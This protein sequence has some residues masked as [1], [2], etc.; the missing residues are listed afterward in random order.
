MSFWDPIFNTNDA[1]ASE[2]KTPTTTTP[3]SV[4]TPTTSKSSFWEG[5][6]GPLAAKEPTPTPETPTA[7]VL[8]SY[9]SKG[10]PSG[11][12]IGYS[13]DQA[14]TSGKPFFAY[15][16]PGDTATTTDRTRV[17]TTFDPTIATTTNSKNFYNPR[18]PKVTKLREVMGASYSD[19]LDHK[20]SLE[21]SGSNTQENLQ[22]EPLKPG[23]NKTATDALENSLARDVANGRKS[24]VEAQTELATAKKLKIPW[25]PPE[26][27]PKKEASFWDKTKA[28]LGSVFNKPETKPV[29]FPEFKFEDRNTQKPAIDFGQAS[30]KTA[31]STPGP[32]PV[33][34]ADIP[35]EQGQPETFW[36]RAQRQ[37]ATLTATKPSSGIE[38]FY[39]E[40]VPPVVKA[41]V[42]Q[43]SEGIKGRGQVVDMAGNLVEDKGFLEN[44]GLAKSDFAKVTDR[45]NELVN[46]G[47]D[48]TR[49]TQIAVTY[50]NNRVSDP[51][52]SMK[53]D[54]IQ[55]KTIAELNLTP[56]EKSAL[57]KVALF[58][59]VNTAL[60]ALN[61][62]GIGMVEKKTL[63][64]ISKI[65]AKETYTVP[66]KNILVK[67]VPNITP[68]MAQSA[69]EILSNVKDPAL[70]EKFISEL[71][72]SINKFTPKTMAAE[73][74]AIGTKETTVAKPAV[75]EG[76]KDLSTKTL[77]KL[78]GKTTVSKQFISDLTNSS[79]L[80]QEE[81]DVLL[82]ALADYKD[83]SSVPVKEFA[84]KV[85]AELLPLNV[86]SP[87][88]S[89]RYERVSLPEDQ[90]GPI[91]S[92]YE[93]IYNSPVKTSAGDIH[94]DGATAN[95][96]GHTRV[97]DLPE[98][99]GTRRVIEVQ[100]DLFQKGNIEKQVPP[101]NVFNSGLTV[102]YKGKPY[103]VMGTAG[104]RTFATL[105]SGDEVINNVYV[106][107]VDLTPSNE[108]IKKRAQEVSKLQ[109]YT[110]P[111]AHFRMVRE[112]IK[113]AAQDGKTKLQFP[114][115][116]TAMK[117]EG[118]GTGADIW[119]TADREMNLR[120]EM[121]KVGKEITQGQNSKW[122]ITDVLGNGKFKAVQKYF[123][124]PM[125]ARWLDIEKDQNWESRLTSHAET[126]D[127][128]GKVDTNNPIYKFYEKDLGRY[129]T[130]K[131]GA[132]V[133]TDKQGVKWY[134]ID[135]K[136]EQAKQP[137][138][139]F[140]RGTT[141]GKI[142]KQAES[143][144]VP[145]NMTI[146][147]AKKEIEKL[148]NPK[149]IDFLFPSEIKVE[150][151]EAW[152]RSTV[153]R[154]FKNPLIE[155]VQSNGKIND[156]TLYHES[157]HTYLKQFVSPEE[158][159]ALLTAI[160]KNKTSGLSR[161]LYKLD[162][163]NT[164]DER[165]EEYAA[166]A[167]ADYVRSKKAPKGTESIFAKI[168][169]RVREWIRKVTG[170]QKMFD[171][172]LSKKRT[173]AR[174]NYRTLDVTSFKNKK[175]LTPKIEGESVASK[176]DVARDI[177]NQ[178]EKDL[179]V[180]PVEYTVIKPTRE[181][182]LAIEKGYK[183]ITKIE[184]EAL[185]KEKLKIKFSPEM[186]QK[187]LGLAIREEELSN[188]RL[189]GLTKFASKTGDNAG[190]LPEVTGEIGK[191]MFKQRGDQYISEIAGIEDTEVARE[192]FEK[193]V[194]RKKMF[195]EDMKAFM[196]EKSAFLREERAKRKE[197]LDNQALGKM[198]TAQEKYIS[199]V[200]GDKASREARIKRIQ[201]METRKQEEFKQ[202]AFMSA[203]YSRKVEKANLESGQKKNLLAKFKQYLAPISQTDKTTQE[204]WLNWETKKLKAKEMGND[205]YEKFKAQPENDMEA[206]LE[207]EAG[208]PIAW[209]RNEFDSL[210]TEAQRAGLH[211]NYKDQYIPH[212][213]KE[214]TEQIQKAIVKYMEANKVEKQVIDA[215]KS[216]G[217]IP[218]KMAVRLKIR[219]SF[220]RIRS[221]PDYATAM[222][223]G[224]TPR[225]NTIAEHIAFY[226]QEMEKTI[227][228]KKL[229]DDLIKEGKVLPAEDAPES[230]I[231]VK[232][233]GRT[234]R[235]YWG[236]KN[237]A[238]AL[239]GQFRDE[240]NL[241]FGQTVFKGIAKTAQIMQEIKLSA[242]LPG[243]NINF[244]SIGQAI[245]SLTVGL[246][247]ALKGNLAG[248]STS[249][250]A[251]LAFIRA[252]FND[253][254]IKWL[255]SNKKYIDM[256]A[257]QNIPLTRRVDDF[258][259][260]HMIWRNLL[261]AR[262]LKEAKRSLGIW[263]EEVKGAKGLKEFGKSLIS[264]KDSRAIAISKD[265]FDKSFNEKTFNSMM[266][267]MQIQV[268]K[269]IYEGAVRK[270]M[271]EQTAKEF[272]GATVKA[273]FG[274]INDL[275]RTQNSKDVFGAVF[276]APKFREGIINIFVNAAKSYSTEFRNPAFSRSRSFVVG[277][278]VSFIAYNYINQKLNNGDNMWDNAPGH[279]FDLKVPLPNG[280]ILYTSFMPSVLSFIRN[281]SSAAINFAQGRNDIALQK[282]GSLLSM[283]MAM[284]SQ[285]VS[286]KDFFDRP[287]Y[288][289]TDDA[290]TKAK[291]A[292]TYMGLGFTHPY[293]SELVKYFQGSQDIFQTISAMTELP[294]KFS[295][296]DKATVAKAYAIKQTQTE[297]S[298]KL[299]SDA[300]KEWS[301]LK[302]LP[303][304]ATF[305]AE[306]D[307][308]A[309]N[310]PD[311]AK[312][313]TSIYN[314]EQKGLTS[315]DRSMLMLGVNNGERAQFVVGNLKKAKTE[316]EF[317]K[318]WDEYVAKKIITKE[319]SKQINE[320]WK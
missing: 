41:I 70:V 10:F 243:S 204:I 300:K 199:Q 3:K 165:A 205:T 275:G 14:D 239:N 311:L 154:A 195:N 33:F 11:A 264:I 155:V 20:I 171:E 175:G 148:F 279:E 223:Y 312:K 47:V 272:A 198:Y 302:A 113:Q 186:E 51:L 183:E 201:E 79:D 52:G 102:N 135:V 288:A 120:P 301:R 159:K 191:G 23:S 24:L 90:R 247:E 13:Q 207:Y 316:A 208:K 178:A 280:K 276:F 250:K 317:N 277:A 63:G 212:A 96:F 318:L 170:M 19:Q 197:L 71:D 62:T 298:Q 104:G 200:L 119:S 187:A 152:G 158:R 160:K 48:P 133:V 87:E 314:D 72:F 257:E 222:R 114:T 231:E 73:P 161:I 168:L 115:G 163:Y 16:N 296:E 310:N 94:F 25:L 80:K 44:F 42:D 268:F 188:N 92:Y 274:R 45:Y 64:S 111:T 29:V 281:M 6:N 150:G 124:D 84:D 37:G 69:A 31:M 15:R 88:N 258:T 75:F 238:D 40:K 53:A 235:E 108:I 128:S 60:D 290:T 193:Y 43:I 299:L 306:F 289:V 294:L 293:F 255:Q 125:K 307:K 215:Y 132:K 123:Y 134:E 232:L 127:I 253:R 219:P 233:P 252:N 236:P 30:T 284:V 265:I 167:F 273:E 210:F 122:I 263:K 304:E 138:Q 81:R 262:N 172:I 181:D 7:P 129:L 61:F 179:G 130:N 151:G 217:E 107:D 169:S 103:K 28:V 245:K 18:D 244:F 4:S 56:D 286:N 156:S 126:F 182:R 313:I 303:N 22:L 49:A 106:D 230:W 177:L 105:K 21:L 116:E 174:K 136:P 190:K 1:G 147:E 206:V 228:N 68:E 203:E 242:G 261:T 5:L 320:L 121:L 226:K 270:G 85:K 292:I 46:K 142:E 319:V 251:S 82:N 149:E 225:F 9:F 218:E 189:K 185:F 241:T 112:E 157:F 38:K 153:G 27:Q 315:A 144:G 65:I 54:E 50:A 100:S 196:K 145:F 83:G 35:V 137:V 77:D 95:Y 118:L 8:S 91:D 55:K 309:Q 256:M 229:I 221:F 209:V 59:T 101:T 109:Q 297:A 74:L 141:A 57:N 140:K 39:E 2:T 291:K 166:D 99:T 32:K 202:K 224:L 97:E 26:L 269:D 86:A 17:A 76:Y 227:A 237:L 295:T 34:L 220:T 260:N 139:A 249:V 192:E 117:I 58:E 214:K 36:D 213:Y 285:V 12:T 143:Q 248:A 278:I 194:E 176:I 110:N 146:E 267:Q 67:N 162:K 164:P 180:A 287:I 305:N 254:S 240:A 246:G 93:N 234:F 78:V 184:G 283:P 131:Y 173:Y 98:N 211:V 89:T 66:I 266:P 271:P 259:Q 282:A 216:G 308:I